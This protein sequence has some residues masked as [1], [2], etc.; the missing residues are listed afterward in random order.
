MSD[1]VLFVCTGNTCRSPMAAAIARDLAAAGFG[2]PV[3]FATVAARSKAASAAGPALGYCQ[4]TPLRGEIEARDPKRLQEVTDAA[5][6]AIAQR[7]GAGPVDAKI[8][9]IVVSVEA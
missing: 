7:F 5:A 8:Q 1:R 2:K 3:E 9:A 6:A 4:G